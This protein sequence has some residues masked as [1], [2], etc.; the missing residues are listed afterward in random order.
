M[1]NLQAVYLFGQSAGGYGIIGTWN[2]ARQVF[3]TPVHTLADS[4]PFLQPAGDRWAQ[5][6]TNWKPVVA[7]AGCADC[8]DGMGPLFASLADADP[9][10]RHG[11]LAFTNDAVLQA[12]FGFVDQRA[13]LAAFV[14][15]S[16]DP[17][18]NTRYLVVEGTSHV[19]FGQ[20]APVVDPGPVAAFVGGWLTGGPAFESSSPF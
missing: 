6:R 17:R 8:A 3:Q 9:S 19:V 2:I 18:P 20:G 15:K 10:S 16:Y 1:P 12:F 13:E 11:L 14:K 4:S 7:P 5:I